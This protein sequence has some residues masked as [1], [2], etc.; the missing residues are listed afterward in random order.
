MTI[1]ERIT[2][3]DISYIKA[4]VSAFYGEQTARKITS[5]AVTF[6]TV[7]NVALLLRETVDCSKWVD[8]VPNPQDLLFP[9]KSL[10]KWALRVLRN[11][12]KPF[13]LGSLKVNIMCKSF[14]AAQFKPA[15]LSSLK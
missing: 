8:S 12:G 11:A 7:H 15:I 14:R 2:A 10:H 13:L 5:Q 9:A 4:I 6:K 1:N 3:D